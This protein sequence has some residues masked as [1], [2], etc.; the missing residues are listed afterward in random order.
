MARLKLISL[1][2]TTTE[3]ST[4]ADEPYLLV[5]GNRV[6]GSSSLNDGET[7]DLSQVPLISF[8]G[9][10]S[11]KLFDDDSPDGDDNLGTHTA[12]ESQAGRGTQTGTFTQDDADYTLTYE[13]LA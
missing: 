5:N 10:A 9:T 1:H 13:V 8:N 4:G 2:C 12:N 7:A 6:W 3:D 11:I